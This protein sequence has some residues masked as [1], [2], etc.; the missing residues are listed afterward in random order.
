MS[1]SEK[2]KALEREGAEGEWG[3]YEEA[4]HDPDDD[5]KYTERWL[6]DN[7]VIL[8]WEDGYIPLGP[9]RL[10]VNLR[11]ALPQIVAVVD[12]AWR[13]TSHHDTLMD[14]LD[15]PLCQAL[16]ALEEALP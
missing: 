11:N 2:L 3:I 9:A 14:P 7:G 13:G 6:T 12:E 15:C 16:A 5:P 10:I 4:H 8:N 1:A